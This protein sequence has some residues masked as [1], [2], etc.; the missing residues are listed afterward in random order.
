MI[1]IGIFVVCRAVTSTWRLKPSHNRTQAG[2]CS[3]AQGVY[4]EIESEGRK[5]NVQTETRVNQRWLSALTTRQQHGEVSYK[6][7]GCSTLRGSVLKG[8]QNAGSDY[9]RYE[10]EADEITTGDLK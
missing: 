9:G 4:R 1:F 3:Q 10:W 8:L 5:A 6:T 7:N 2:L